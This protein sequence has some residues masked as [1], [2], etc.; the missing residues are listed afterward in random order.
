MFH[1]TK[2]PVSGRTPRTRAE[3]MNDAKNFDEGPKYDYQNG[4]PVTQKMP[5]QDYKDTK[6]PEKAP[7]GPKDIE[8]PFTIKGA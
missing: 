3:E 4:H 1:G 7:T 6:L 2:G 8:A 5:S